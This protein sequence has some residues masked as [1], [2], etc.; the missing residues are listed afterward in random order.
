VVAGLLLSLGVSRNTSYSG[1]HTT[2]WL[3]HLDYESVR[4]G[5]S[6]P[7]DASIMLSHLPRYRL[8]LRAHTAVA[9]P[10]ETMALVHL[11]AY[12][13]RIEK[14]VG[15][16]RDIGKRKLLISSAS[17]SNRPMLMRDLICQ[18]SEET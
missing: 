8:H 16:Y 17:I 12:Y 5:P 15:L 9:L 3:R 7:E 6:G 13:R 14:L 18:R 11:Y 10:G 2:P 4:G 1:K